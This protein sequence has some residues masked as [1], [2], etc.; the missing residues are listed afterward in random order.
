M[1]LKRFTSIIR[2]LSWAAPFYKWKI[3]KNE[4]PLCGE[5]F[6]IYLNNDPFMIRC[7]KCKGNITNLAL[8]PVIKEFIKG[9]FNSSVYELSSYGATLDYLKLHFKNVVVSEYFQNEKLGDYVNNILNQDVQNLTFRDNMF[10]LI[11][12]SQ[13]FEHVENDI[14]GFSE[15]YRVLN[16]GGVFLFS[17]P[18]YNTEKTIKIASIIEGEIKFKGEPEYHDSRLGGVNSAPVFYRHS[19]NDICERVKSVGFL[20]VG[21]RE[22]YIV[23]N[24]KEPQLVVYAIK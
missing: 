21:L 10:D 19:K 11:T 20:E 7:L 24:Q 12:S 5:S 13:V 22:V 14:K 16:K 2:Y 1:N 3:R 8:I 17:V 23:K 4:C 18:L 6:F 15:C 9:D